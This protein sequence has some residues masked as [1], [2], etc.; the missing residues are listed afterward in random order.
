M[1]LL[2]PPT[3]PQK[4]K[5][6]GQKGDLEIN[7]NK[8]DEKGVVTNSVLIYPMTTEPIRIRIPVKLCGQQANVLVSA[9]EG[10]RYLLD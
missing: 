1:D 6:K 8:F 2:E 3:A 7:S 9:L 5:F 4:I 10:S